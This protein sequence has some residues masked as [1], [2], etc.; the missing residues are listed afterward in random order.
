MTLVT[1]KTDNNNN[2]KSSDARTSIRAFSY[3]KSK[4]QMHRKAFEPSKEGMGKRF[5]S[6]NHKELT[7]EKKMRGVGKNL[8]ITKRTSD[9]KSPKHGPESAIKSSFLYP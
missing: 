8:Q 4:K 5:N 1:Q 9:K 7:A 3:R 6:D 2:D